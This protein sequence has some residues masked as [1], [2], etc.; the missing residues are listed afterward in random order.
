MFYTHF[1]VVPSQQ[2]KTL[3]TWFD[4]TILSKQNC[5]DDKR[6]PLI[7]KLPSDSSVAS[8]TSLLVKLLDFGHR[9]KPACMSIMEEMLGSNGGAFVSSVETTQVRLEKNIKNG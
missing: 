3:T 7:C 6:C 1:R 5:S 4:A 2:E 8:F 9:G